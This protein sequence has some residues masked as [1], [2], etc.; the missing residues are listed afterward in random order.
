MFTAPSL[1]T[2]D[3]VGSP[4]WQNVK[5]Y[6]GPLSKSTTLRSHWYPHPFWL[7]L[8]ENKSKELIAC[9]TIH[10]GLIDTAG[11]KRW[12]VC[13]IGVEAVTVLSRSIT[14]TR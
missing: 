11:L 5:F 10:G 3:S 14:T 12:T 4:R 1:L 13:Q 9:P 8:P 7:I 2:T 6:G